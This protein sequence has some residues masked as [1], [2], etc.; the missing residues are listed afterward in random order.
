M[1]TRESNLTISRA[2]LDDAHAVAEIHVRTWRSAYASILSPEYLASLSVA[3]RAE[4]WRKTITSGS[5]ELR[6]AKV[7]GGI[8]GFICF[9]PCREDSVPASEAEIWAIYVDPQSWGSGI[10]RELWVHARQAMQEQG[11]RTCSL[12]VFP[13]NHRAIRFYKSVGFLQDE[14]RTKTI[15]LG[16]Q[17]HQE[18]RYTMAI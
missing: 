7:A 5:P 4:M 12:W 1:R 16:G 11:F 14:S 3:T 10:G 2:N 18:A 9:G 15:E 17:R 13:Q 6:L 8:R